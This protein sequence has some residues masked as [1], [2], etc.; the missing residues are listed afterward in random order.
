MRSLCGI[1]A[2]L[3]L[4][5]G[6]AHC[7]NMYP[8]RSQDL[9]QLSEARDH[10]LLLL[11]QWLKRW[12]SLCLK[13]QTHRSW[14]LKLRTSFLSLLPNFKLLEILKCVFAQVEKFFVLNEFKLW[15]NKVFFLIDTKLEIFLHVWFLY[16]EGVVLLN[17]NR[18]LAS[19]GSDGGGCQT[20]SPHGDPS[21]QSLNHPS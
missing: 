16:C 2:V 21:S 19:R 17:A 3:F 18:T 1:N 13:K 20:A 10:V 6:T 7:A 15:F 4:D 11:Q 9:P 5:S 12:A 8:A 14:F